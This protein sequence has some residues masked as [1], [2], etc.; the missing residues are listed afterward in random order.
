MN[1]LLPYHFELSMASNEFRFPKRKNGDGSN[2]VIFGLF[3]SSPFMHFQHPLAAPDPYNP[4]GISI[5]TVNN[6]EWRVDKFADIGKTK[7]RN[8]TTTF[9]KAIQLTG[10]SNYLRNQPL[11]C[12]GRLLLNIPSVKFIKVKDR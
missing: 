6:P 2:L 11:S 9:G 12:F 8:N 5:E 4:N 10:F 7:F 3:R 1:I